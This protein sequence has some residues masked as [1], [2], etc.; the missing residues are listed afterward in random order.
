MNTTKKR[1]ENRELK[2]L[3]EDQQVNNNNSTIQYFGQISGI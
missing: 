2:R 3:T 1:K